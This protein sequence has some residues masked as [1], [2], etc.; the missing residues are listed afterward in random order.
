MEYHDVHT[1]SYALSAQP[2]PSTTTISKTTTTPPTSTTTPTTTTVANRTKSS[3]RTIVSTRSTIPNEPV[4]TTPS[5]TTHRTAQPHSSTSH[6]IWY[7]E[8][9]SPAAIDR[10]TTPTKPFHRTTIGAIIT[11]RIFSTFEDK[12]STQLFI[13][14]LVGTILTLVTPMVVI[15]TVLVVAR[16]CHLSFKSKHHIPVTSL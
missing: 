14:S 1:F 8:F 16:Y 7:T 6:T 15:V 11:S 13:F 2:E 4:T 12:R 10:T 5:I 3:I 9:T